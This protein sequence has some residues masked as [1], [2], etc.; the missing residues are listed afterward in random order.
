MSFYEEFINGLNPSATVE[1][2]PT[3]EYDVR[4]ET[5]TE[6]EDIISMEAY[7]IYV[8]PIVDE[9]LSKLGGATESLFDGKLTVDNFKQLTENFVNEYGVEDNSYAAIAYE[10]SSAD[11]LR[12][13]KDLEEIKARFEAVK[14]NRSDIDKRLGVDTHG[15]GLFGKAATFGKSLLGIKVNG[16]VV[17]KSAFVKAYNDVVKLL[18]TGSI[19]SDIQQ[20][21]KKLTELRQKISHLESIQDKVLSLDARD[22]KIKESVSNAANKAVTSA[23]NVADNAKETAKEMK[24]DYERAQQEKYNRKSEANVEKAQAKAEQTRY[25]AINLACAKFMDAWNA[26]QGFQERAIALKNEIEKV[27][28][29]STA[30]ESFEQLLC[31]NPEV[32]YAYESYI[33]T[34]NF[35]LNATAEGRIEVVDLAEESYN[36]KQEEEQ[37][38]TYIEPETIGEDNEEEVAEESIIEVSDEEILTSAME[39]KIFLDALKA[40]CTPEEFKQILSENST[41]LQLYGVVDPIAIA[42]ESYEEEDE[43]YEIATEAKS[44]VRL[45]KEAKI[46]T[47]EARIAIGL[48]KK[49]NDPLYK[50]YKKYSTLKRQFRDKIYAKYG[51]RAKPLARK[52]ITNGRNRVAMMNSPAGVS[53]VNKIDSRLKQLNKSARNMS[54]IKPDVKAVKPSMGKKN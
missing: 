42:K 26:N 43:E 35:L 4:E 37:I 5:T 3:E 54:A 25:R 15:K 33:D 47:E 23:K 19:L 27:I 53:I 7:Q 12:A 45:S 24:N 50:S 40:T 51:S 31:N 9:F 52:A 21:P 32:A 8:E 14:S 28:G 30:K 11:R 16:Q 13:E 17:N 38:E 44:I 6:S 36:I 46:N 39:S 18:N 20:N 48:A 22:A 1:N 49:S 41:E 34:I 2:E 29:N 10:S